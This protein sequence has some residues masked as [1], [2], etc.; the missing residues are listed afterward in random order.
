MMVVMLAAA[1][2]VPVAA[3]A[4]SQRPQA[5][6]ELRDVQGKQR[7][8]RELRGKVVLVNFWATWCAPCLSELPMLADLA[9]RYRNA[10]L[11]VV[12]ASVD[13]AQTLDDV[14]ALARKRLRALDVWVGAD[15][16]DMQAL[17]LNGGA[18]P[19]TLLVDRHGRIV[20]RA[21]GSLPHGVLDPLIE[22]LLSEKG[23]NKQTPDDQPK[24][25]GCP[26]KGQGGAIE[27]AAALTPARDASCSEP[28]VS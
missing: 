9:E 27:A 4:Q 5:K 1:A 15:A 2:S 24:P 19:A 20:K 22:E 16:N 11:V 7:S 10:G 6:L 21:Q 12:A 28:E 23:G 17:G 14:Q 25:P 13:D 26:Y 8:L 3:H 18:V